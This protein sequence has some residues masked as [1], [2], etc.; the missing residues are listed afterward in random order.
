MEKIGEDTIGKFYK[1]KILSQKNLNTVYLP[2]VKGQIRIE[3]DLYGVRLYYSSKKFLNLEDEETARYLKIFLEIGLDEI[4][5]PK[6]QDYLKNIL[7][8]LE[9]LKQKIEKILTSNLNF[10]INP[11]TKEKIKNIIWTKVMK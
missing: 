8:E 5:I 3:K 7:P 9:Y 1:E 10:I 4:K 11:K 2:K 6:D